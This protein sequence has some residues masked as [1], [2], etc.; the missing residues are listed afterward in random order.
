[1]V[2]KLVTK[3]NG[4]CDRKTVEKPKRKTIAMCK[5]AR[6]TKMGSTTVLFDVGLDKT[7]NSLTKK[8]R[9][10]PP[11]RIYGSKTK[12]KFEKGGLL[13]SAKGD[14]VTIP[15]TSRTHPV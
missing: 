1:M 4:S 2:V 12:T 14:R 7:I 10:N 15:F 8:T 13:R 11:Y 3:R 5:N 9:E 6:K